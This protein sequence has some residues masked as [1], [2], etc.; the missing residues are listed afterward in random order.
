MNAETAVLRA[1][2]QAALQVAGELD[3]E[4]SAEIAF[5]MTDWLAEL[6]VLSR[7]RTDPDSFDAEATYQAVLRFLLHAPEHIAR[8][9]ELL[10][11]EPIQGIFNDEGTSPK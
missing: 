8:A 6:D 11:G 1:K 5:H 3:A 10:T 2:L 7:L 4:C 9:A